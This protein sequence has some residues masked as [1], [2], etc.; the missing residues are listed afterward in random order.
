M[1]LDFNS[2]KN[3]K[4]DN[5]TEEDIFNLLLI[6]KYEEPRFYN[7]EEVMKSFGKYSNME[8]Y[9]ILYKNLNIKTYKKKFPI[10]D[11]MATYNKMLEQKI[12]IEIVL[13]QFMILASE[14]YINQLK[15]K[16]HKKVLQ[17]FNDLMYFVNNDL[18]YGIDNWEL[19]FEDEIIE[20]PG[21]PSIVTGE[22]IDQEKE[23]EVMQQVKQKSIERL[24]NNSDS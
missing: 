23:E 14:E 1:I 5:L 16:Y 13:N 3:K 2:Y 10:V 19:V 18:K 11:L 15:G 12:L 8:K 9:S 4:I 22:F 6:Y 7:I 17:L 20:I 24:K 21:Y